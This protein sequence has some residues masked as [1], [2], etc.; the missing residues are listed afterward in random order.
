MTLTLLLLVSFFAGSVIFRKT[1]SVKVCAICSAVSLTWL[2]LLLILWTKGSVDPLILGILMGGSAVGAMYYLSAKIP[3]R[4]QLLKF[5]F[6]V[7]LFW[8]AFRVVRG[9]EAAI[10]KEI[11]LLGGMWIIFGAIF[12]LYQHNRLRDIGKRLMECCKDW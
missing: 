12:L 11:I 9:I 8:V 7:S 1:S 5:P 3:E 2:V 10:L 6:L 4:Y